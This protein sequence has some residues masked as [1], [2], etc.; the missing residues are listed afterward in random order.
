[1][2]LRSLEPLASNQDL[3]KWRA[4]S[5]FGF[6]LENVKDVDGSREVDSVDGAKRIPFDA[7]GRFQNASATEAT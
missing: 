3:A 2:S 4:N 7:G 1:M 5:S 6:L